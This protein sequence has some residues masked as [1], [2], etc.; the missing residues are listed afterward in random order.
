MHFATKKPI[1]MPIIISTAV[2]I[3]LI[4]DSIKRFF[5]E[6]EKLDIKEFVFF[7]LNIQYF[8]MQEIKKERQKVLHKKIMDKLSI[9]F[10]KSCLIPLQQALHVH[11]LAHLGNMQYKAFLLANRMRV[12]LMPHQQMFLPP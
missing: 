10:K 7:C 2:I 1:K 4:F 12:Q 8:I 6:Y 11:M 3:N 9:I 5:K